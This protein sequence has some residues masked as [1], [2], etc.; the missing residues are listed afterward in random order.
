MFRRNRAQIIDFP[1]QVQTQNLPS[2]LPSE[3]F[4]TIITDGY[5]QLLAFDGS[6]D[7]S[8]VRD[9]V[10][11]ATRRGFGVKVS[12]NGKVLSEQSATG[13]VGIR[14]VANPRDAYDMGYGRSNAVMAKS[15]LM[16]IHRIAQRL[17]DALMDGDNLPQWVHTKIATSLDRLSTAANYLETKI[18]K[19]NRGM[20][21]NPNYLEKGDQMCAYAWTTAVVMSPIS[22]GDL[23]EA[24]SFDGF[25]P[26]II[27]VI[28]D[29]EAKSGEFVTDG[30]PDNVQDEDLIVDADFA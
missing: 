14:R 9:L 6:S 20:R 5:G 29:E 16:S 11:T 10:N 15:Q 7:D 27:K 24:A 3:M 1:I 17:D 30:D 28:V 22:F 4:V 12:Q 18:E 13:E 23:K 26:M 19:M 21:R 2:F 25:D 8:E